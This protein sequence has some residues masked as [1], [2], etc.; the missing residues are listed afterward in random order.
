MTMIE[1][2]NVVSPL[3]EQHQIV[4]AKEQAFEEYT[5]NV[6]E[7]FTRMYNVL[8]NIDNDEK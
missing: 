4:Y 6:D 7:R 2:F 5:N 1:T 3:L 8:S